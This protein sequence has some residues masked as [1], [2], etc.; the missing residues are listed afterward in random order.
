MRRFLFST[1]G[2]MLATTVVAGALM[3]FRY[4]IRHGDHGE[5]L[6][7]TALIFRGGRTGETGPWKRNWCHEIGVTSIFP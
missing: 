7:V 1:W 4:A 6:C 3:V 5:F 2:L